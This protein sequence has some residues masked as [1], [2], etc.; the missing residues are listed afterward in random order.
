MYSTFFLW[1][2]LHP[3]LIACFQKFPMLYESSSLP[4]EFEMGKSLFSENI[5]ASDIRLLKNDVEICDEVSYMGLRAWVVLN[6]NGCRSVYNAHCLNT[7]AEYMDYAA[8]HAKSL[9]KKV[10]RQRFLGDMKDQRLKIDQK[11]SIEN[12]LQFCVLCANSSDLLSILQLLLNAVAT[13]SSADLRKQCVGCLRCFLSSLRPVY[14]ISLLRRLCADCPFKSLTGALIDYA[15]TCFQASSR[16]QSLTTAYGLKR[17]THLVTEGLSVEENRWTQCMSTQMY[18]DLKSNADDLTLSRDSVLL[19]AG[20]MS[21]SMNT[22]FDISF[23]IP[24]LLKELVF[25]VLN[26]YYSCDTSTVSLK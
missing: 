21:I 3:H 18:C 24:I 19:R 20:I 7:S 10:L 12:E 1:N 22:E 16:N 9:W 25:P 8:L 11:Q 6:S 13:C 5:G 17:E 15:K 26:S 23:S 14:R 2:I 4:L